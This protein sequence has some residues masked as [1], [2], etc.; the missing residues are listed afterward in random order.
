[1]PSTPAAPLLLST[2]F[3]A[4]C[5]FSLS[6]TAS[7]T[8]F[9]RLNPSPTSDFPSSRAGDASTLRSPP[10]GFTCF[11][12]TSVPPS[13]GFCLP[14]SSRELLVVLIP[15]LVQPF[16]HHRRGTMA[17]ADSCHLSLLSR[18]GLPL[19]LDDRSP[20]VRTLTFPASLSHLLDQ[21]LV[22]SGFVVLCQLAR[23]V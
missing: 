15:L 11:G 3:R 14:G 2:R 6:N 4:V 8:G 1:M 19:R 12:K 23:L 5:R 17:S 7:H 22:A 10:T 16:P 13:E 18:T 20:Q 21:P 9:D